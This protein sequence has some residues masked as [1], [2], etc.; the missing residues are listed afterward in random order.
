MSDEDILC[1][2][3]QFLILSM[4]LL[5]PQCLPIGQCNKLFQ[6]EFH[7]RDSAEMYTRFIAKHPDRHSGV[8]FDYLDVYMVARTTF[9]G[10][11]LLGGEPDDHWDEP[12]SL[13]SKRSERAQERWL[14]QEELDP[15]SRSR[16]SYRTY[17]RRHLPSPIDRDFRYRHSVASRTPV[18]IVEPKV[19][20]F[21][22]AMR[23]KEEHD[24][25]DLIKRMHGP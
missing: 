17:E 11:H 4:P 8:N 13:A 23:E 19:V 2:C 16:V 10:N 21:K 22:E 1:Y 15:P 9:S 24:V 3:G 6:R 18:P 20:R 7:R 14:D 12:Q 5:N 25:E